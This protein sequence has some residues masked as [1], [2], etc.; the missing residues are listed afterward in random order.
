[1][2]TPAP[3]RYLEHELTVYRRLWRSSLVSSFLA[4]VL[5]LA[6]IGGTVGKSI[7]RHGVGHFGGA[8]YIEWLAPG[9]MAAN[10]MQVAVQEC[11]HPV[12]GGFKWTRTFLAAAT[13]PLTPDDIVTGWLTWVGLRALLVSSVYL[14]VAAAFGAVPSATAILAIPV[15]ALTGL[16][17]AGPAT[18][19]AATRER[20]ESFSTLQRF[21]V[22]PLSLFSGG[23]FPIT[24]LPAAVRP[25]AY[26]LPL[27]HGVVLCRALSLG[28]AGWAASLGHVAVLAGYAGVGTAFAVVTFRR[29]LR[30]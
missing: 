18:A 16:A 30:S 7:D 10:A 23:F 24:Q 5:F 9:L 17:F 21:G 6:A 27:W 28:H 1:M 26:V 25:I 14:L 13:T 19:W 22:L 29:R 12:L 20:D 4:P 3:V 15:A 2:A 8:T 11:F